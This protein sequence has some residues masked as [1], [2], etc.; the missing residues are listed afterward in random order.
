MPDALTTL[1]EEWGLSLEARTRVERALVPMLLGL[2]EPADEQD[3]AI[4]AS[5]FGGCPDL[6]EGMA[7]PSSGDHPT[8]FL[9]QVDLSALPSTGKLPTTGLLSFFYDDAGGPAGRRSRVLHLEGELTR[10]DVVV[11]P[12]YEEGFLARLLPPRRL[13]FVPGWNLPP[14]RPP[15]LATLIDDY[16]VLR[17]DLWQLQTT[18]RRAHQLLGLPSASWEPRGA[19][20][21]WELL[22]QVAD[23]NDCVSF[24]LPPGAL[25]ERRFD[26]AVAHYET[27]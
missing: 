13:D 1:N 2:Y 19:L 20:A 27:T 26:H 14:S 9:A 11:D 18:G 15:E 6:P 21:R 12:R 5:K 4:G 16:D 24:V 25:A 7:W 8:W 22:L 17:A 23:M 10:H 3:I